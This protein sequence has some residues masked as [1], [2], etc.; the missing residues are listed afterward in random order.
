M[1]SDTTTLISKTF[2]PA[3]EVDPMEGIELTRMSSKGQVV[4]PQSTRERMKLKEGDTLA[5]FG[6]GDTLILKIVHMP[7]PKEMFEK[8]HAWGVK[9]TKERGIKQSEVQ[10][11]IERVRARERQ[12]DANRR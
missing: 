8:M 4:I 3:I 12:K 1:A 5:V 6:S 10:G 2:L 11:I 7:S 9:T